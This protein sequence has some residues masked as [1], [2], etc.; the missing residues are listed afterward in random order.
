MI[1]NNGAQILMNVSVGEKAIA[2][3][4]LYDEDGNVIANI[5]TGQYAFSRCTKYN[6]IHNVSSSSYSG[7][8]M[9]VGVGDAAENVNDYWLEETEINGVDVNTIITLQSVSSVWYPT[10]TSSGK[11]VYTF[12]FRNEGNTSIII[13]EI[14]LI[15]VNTNS[16]VLLARRTITPRTV[17]PNETVTFNYEIGCN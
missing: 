1:T 13:K 7:T 14:G 12:S 2:D 10:F 9:I 17:A 11:G 5:G 3:C 16:R 8:T 6:T 4:S 15:Y